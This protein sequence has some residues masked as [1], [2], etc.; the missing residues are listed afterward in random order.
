MGCFQSTESEFTIILVHNAALYN[1]NSNISSYDQLFSSIAM[2]TGFNN[3][4]LICLSNSG[5]PFTF[6]TDETWDILRALNMH[7]HSIFLT[8]YPE[9][10]A[11]ILTIPPHQPK[12]SKEYYAI[13]NRV[14]LFTAHLDM[15]DDYLS[16]FVRSLGL[17]CMDEI[18]LANVLA[19]YGMM[20]F[21]YLDDISPT[22][23]YFIISEDSKT[24]MTGEVRRILEKWECL[25]T[26]LSD[27]DDDYADLSYNMKF[28]L[29]QIDTSF[30]TPRKARRS[31]SRANRSSLIAVENSLKLSKASE[32]LK[33]YRD[34][35]ELFKA[36]VGRALLTLREDKS[37]ILR[38]ISLILG[39]TGSYS[40]GNA[41]WV[42]GLGE[43]STVTGDLFFY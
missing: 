9:D 26:L 30:F 6:V 20:I 35:M 4:Q 33:V 24:C 39:Q 5:V 40:W 14:A 16:K 2:I 11:D 42:F 7:N 32:V 43:L 41:S 23:P 3:F 17:Y 25:L 10:Q 19:I 18:C 38:N 15:F 21:S 8:V 12:F 13:S 28:I 1:L 37:R 22:Y 36:A 31:I 29:C 27:L 34:K